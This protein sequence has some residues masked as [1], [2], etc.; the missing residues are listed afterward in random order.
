MKTKNLFVTLV[1]LMALPLSVIAATSTDAL[2]VSGAFGG[3]PTTVSLSNFSLTS[4]AKYTGSFEYDPTYML[5]YMD[6][7]KVWATVYSPGKAKS[8]KIYWDGSG[9]YNESGVST[10]YVYGQNGTPYTGSETKGSVTGSLLGSKTYAGESS[11]TID[12]SAGNCDYIAIVADDEYG[13]AFN[14]V[15][16]T[17]TVPD[18][19][20]YAITETHT[21]SGSVTFSP[22]S[23]VA[24]GTTVTVTFSGSGGKNETHSY[25]IDGNATDLG[26]DGYQKTVSTTFVMPAHAVDVSAVFGSKPTRTENPI[27]VDGVASDKSATIESGT[28]STFT[29]S[30]PYNA[31]TSPA[32]NKTLKS[33]TSA[34]GRVEIVSNTYSSS[35]GSGTLTLRG[36]TTG[37]DVIT[38]TT[39][40][41]NG[42][43]RS[44]RRINITVVSRNVALITEVNGKH[45]ALTNSPSGTMAGA[46]ELLEDGGIYYYK[47]AGNL[48][49]I[50]WKM[51]NSNAA[52]TKFRIK[53]GTGKYLTVDA[54]TMS[55][56]ST[57]FDWSLN[58][59]D[60]LITGYLTGMCYNE[61]YTAFTVNNQNEHLG[62]STISACVREVPIA[63]LS[64]AAEYTRSLTNGNY[65]TMCLPFAVSASETFFSGVEVYNITG[66]HMSGSTLTGIELEQETGALVAGKPYIILATASSMSAWHGTDV[67]GSPI[68]ATGLVGNLNSTP[69]AVPSGCYGI[70]GNKIRKV[71]D[72][73]GTIG[74]YRAYLDLTYVPEVGGASAPGRRVLY[75]ESTA[76]SVEDLLENATFIN[77]NEPVYNMLGQQ[78]GKG[79]T[80]VL[81]QNGQK[82]LVQ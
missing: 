39:Y 6:N 26:E 3:S 43:S 72:G 52:G 57:P 58:A 56:E 53:N 31:S 41:T 23:P 36:L 46:I 30:T 9:E 4:G 66:K 65:A 11:Y 42:T 18:V 61:G 81:I 78:V 76:T 47:S 28:T 21:G 71:T 67:V 17:W 51:E 34:N 82:F 25:V 24:E 60:R 70:S 69:L 7:L 19:T 68:S 49:D 35:T 37:A 14:Q 2:S 77:W 59:A 16:I 20:T 62:T 5:G 40:Q 13:I 29:I 50:T 79:T 12:V 63:S 75:A 38:I 64:L 48:S 22:A 74:Q 54:A 15:D 8:V 44:D 32:Y 80:G 55:M 73:S 27:S 1:L 10:I 45:Y 33:I